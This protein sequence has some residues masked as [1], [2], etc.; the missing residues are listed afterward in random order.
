MKKLIIS[1]LFA[2]LGIQIMA[3]TPLVKKVVIKDSNGD[4]SS[5]YFFTYYNDGLISSVE[6]HLFL[7]DEV[8][9]FTYNKELGII[10]TEND[11]GELGMGEIRGSFGPR[12]QELYHIYGED[13][14]NLEQYYYS[15][16]GQV[17][18]YTYKTRDTKEI[19][20]YDW[21]DNTLVGVR[22]EDDYG[23][24]KYNTFL[25]YSTDNPFVD[26]AVDPTMLV[27]PFLNTNFWLGFCGKR[28]DHLIKAYSCQSFTMDDEYDEYE[29]ESK[30]NV[31]IEYKRDGKGRIKLILV[32]E[33]GNLS[34]TIEIKY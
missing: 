15:G 25:Y 16:E 4:V 17:L 8:K 31:E 6:C 1:L 9:R 20:Y 21:K 18:Q 28:P 7:F 27:V 5:T 34:K 30:T 19:E 3:Q 12:M 23:M 22:S 33:D 13:E 32:K 24:E 29:F 2:C 14:S 26:C 10:K 11:K